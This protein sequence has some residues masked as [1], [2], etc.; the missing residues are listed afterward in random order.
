MKSPHPLTDQERAAWWRLSRTSGIGPITFFKLIEQ[1]KTATEAINWLPELSRRGGRKIPFSVFGTAQAEDEI[2][3]LNHVG[4]RLI[5]ACEPD[6]PDLLRQIDDAPPVLTVRGNPQTWVN[7]NCLALVGGRNA[8]LP[9]RKM[10]ENLAKD[11]GA[12]GYVVVSGMARGIDTAAH[13]GS[14]KT[15]TVAVMAGG[16]DVV[17]PPENESLY[18][19]ICAQGA[20][21]S[22]HP[23]GTAPK[24]PYF[25][26]RNRLISGMC[27]GTCVV[28]ATVSSGSLITARMA[29]E[30]GRDVFAVPG[31]PMDPR[32]GGP[33]RLIRE[34]AV[35]VERADHITDHLTLFKSQGHLLEAATGDYDRNES[36]PD[37][38]IMEQTRKTIRQALSFTPIVVDEMARACQLNIQ[39]VQI[40]LLEMEL[41]GLV[42]RLPGNRIVLLDKDFLSEFERSGHC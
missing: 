5:A 33:N 23:A 15:G 27:A 3:A 22:E 6:Y 8:S 30:Q 32:A 9:G 28:E 31:S 10:A 36:L 21:I 34:G 37:D 12:R 14:L 26:R 25:P 41:S 7:K 17:Y 39:A 38:Q 16:V 20:V 13:E 42:Q 35:L 2:A 40:A 1:Y 4:A 24:M 18:R 19:E 11:L 29:A